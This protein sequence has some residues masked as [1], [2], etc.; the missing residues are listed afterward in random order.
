MRSIGLAFWNQTWHLSREFQKGLT[1]KSKYQNSRYLHRKLLFF[2]Q[3]TAIF[4]T[5]GKP[6]AGMESLSRLLYN[7]DG[8]ARDDHSSIISVCH[9]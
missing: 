4:S 3:A 1:M 9:H 8:A 6:L 2:L 5:L 7:S